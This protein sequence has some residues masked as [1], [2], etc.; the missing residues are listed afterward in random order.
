MM[1]SD[2]SKQRRFQRELY[3]DVLRLF[4]TVGVISLHVF[5]EGYHLP[6]D[7]FNWCVAV[8]GDSLVRWSVPIF[9]MISGALFLKPEKEVTIQKIIHKY[10]PRLL[11]AYVF[12]WV[13]YTCFH[14]FLA[15]FLE[16][17]IVFNSRFLAPP[18]HLWF[19]PMLMSV[20][21]LIPILRKVA[22]DKT[23][24]N[25]SLLI[26]LIY[27]T[28]SFFLEK[29]IP[30]ISKLFVMNI[31]VG[32]SGYYL[33]GY[34]LSQ[35]KFHNRERLFLLIIGLIGVVITIMG[36]FLSSRHHGTHDVR[37]LFEISPH[38]VMMAAALFSLAK[39]YVPIKEDK[40]FCI[41]DYMRKDLF[42]IYLVHGFWLVVFNR[43]LFRDLSNHIISLPLIIVV[44][45][46][47]SLFT[48]KFFRKVPLL[49]R[50]IE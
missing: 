13:A 44:V 38:V 19:L 40:L 3:L 35:Y 4:A 37:F 11:I 26:W 34:H 43:S 31:V 39:E 32:Y 42:G 24:L 20:Y 18:S 2:Y 10:I 36:S 15:S 17:R 49:K 9:V 7:T 41:V 33:L 25:Y 12:W 22:A 1:A 45:F 21:L 6:I 46:V 30:Q 5:G 27:L 16:N 14:F 47:C 29:E 23:L 50:V 8:V 28:T 48:T